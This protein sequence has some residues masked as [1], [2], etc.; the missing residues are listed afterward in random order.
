MMTVQ[1]GS[2]LENQVDTIQQRLDEG[3]TWKDLTK[4]E[5]KVII[6]ASRKAGLPWRKITERVGKKATQTSTIT[7][8]VRVHL[9]DLM[10]GKRRRKPSKD[11]GAQRT[12]RKRNQEDKREAAAGESDRQEVSEIQHKPEAAV[13]T[14]AFGHEEDRFP[15][16][17]LPVR[18]EKIL[19]TV[20]GIAQQVDEL[21]ATTKQGSTPLIANAPA[22]APPPPPPAIPNPLQ[23]DQAH[24]SITARGDQ[25]Y[26]WSPGAIQKMAR[27]EIENIPST[28]LEELPGDVLTQLNDRMADIQ[29]LEAMTPEERAEYLHQQQVA[30]ELQEVAESNPQEVEE[31]ELYRRRKKYADEYTTC[32]W[33]HQGQW[34]RRLDYWF[35]LTCKL[36]FPFERDAEERTKPA[37]CPRCETRD[38]EP[39]SPR[40]DPVRDGT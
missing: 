8:W 29:K 15:T 3:A 34:N 23:P 26:D 36:K 33:G 17:N 21:V 24:A 35:C 4:E 40:N 30:K 27:A 38:I 5:R 6:C 16:Q 9:P 12:P 2:A 13:E 10:T 37:G 14:V 7:S 22:A 25:A 28:V 39:W 19:E 20:E 32:S 11:S 31:H 18:V 1:E